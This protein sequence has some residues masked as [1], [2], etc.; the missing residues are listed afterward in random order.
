[1]GGFTGAPRLRGREKNPPSVHPWGTARF[2]KPWVCLHAAA[3]CP[4]GCPRSGTH[5][6]AY[7]HPHTFARSPCPCSFLQAR[8]QLESWLPPVTFQNRL[9]I[10]NKQKKQPKNQGGE[11]IARKEIIIIITLRAL[12][13]KPL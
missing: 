9:F 4:H 3:G 8:A 11:K 12:A 7:M 10:K 5:M 6:L 1:M 2:S 13:V